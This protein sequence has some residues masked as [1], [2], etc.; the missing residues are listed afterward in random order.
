MTAP[1]QKT[2]RE[3][4]LTLIGGILFVAYL[5]GMVF[6]SASPVAPGVTSAA[7]APVP[8]TLGSFLKYGFSVLIIASLLFPLLKGKMQP[9]FYLFRLL[10][11]RMVFESIFVVCAVITTAMALVK[12]FPFLDR[13]WLY[14]IPVSDGESTNLAVMPAT[15]KYVGLIFLVLLALCLPRF[16][17]TEEV[18][19]RH[20]TQDWRDG[21]KRS[22]QFGLAH[23]LMGVPL[24]VGLALTV[25][26]LWFTLQYFKGGVER[27]TAYHLAYNL[28]V[29]ALLSTY[30]ILA[31]VII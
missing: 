25:G 20:G 23:C 30:L 10:R 19:Y 6:G 24:Y 11:P 17:Y 12:L 18:K 28:L 26:G 7:P 3:K 14:L 31:R 22:L 1:P 9:Y 2:T 5:L 21:F 16:A 4:W 13:S 29:L 8:S 15:L 27:S